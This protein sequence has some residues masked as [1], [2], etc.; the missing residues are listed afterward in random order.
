[1]K[2]LIASVF[3]LSLLGATAAQAEVG[4]GV[5]VGGVGVHVGAGGHHDRGY[6][7]R[8]CHSWG[9]HRHHRDRYCRGWY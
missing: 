1:M 9:W 3:A 6:H 4:V 5:H 8:R 2:K 7:H